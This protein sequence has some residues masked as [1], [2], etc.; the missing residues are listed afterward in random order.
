MSGGL[1]G[2]T[3][4]RIRPKVARSSSIPCVDKLKRKGG[5]SKERQN[6]IRIGNNL[7]IRSYSLGRKLFLG[8]IIGWSEIFTLKSQKQIK[9]KP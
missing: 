3:R 9:G 2:E 1:V 7:S 4:G 6:K 5:E 8:V